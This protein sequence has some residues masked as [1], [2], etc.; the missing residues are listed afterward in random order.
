MCCFER[1]SAAAP[2]SSHFPEVKLLQQNR[3]SFNHLVWELYVIMSCVGWDHV[4]TIQRNCFSIGLSE[5]IACHSSI[6]H[7]KVIELNCWQRFL[8]NIFFTGINFLSPFPLSAHLYQLLL[9]VKVEWLR[10]FNLVMFSNFDLFNLIFFWGV[11]ILSWFPILI[12]WGFSKI[13]VVVYHFYFLGGFSSVMNLW[14]VQSEV[15]S[16]GFVATFDDEYP[17]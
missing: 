4:V 13:R 12:F 16:W 5:Q 14:F 15:L 17:I 11:L 1:K 7:H 2:N 9:L 10:S 6:V 8:F 3:F